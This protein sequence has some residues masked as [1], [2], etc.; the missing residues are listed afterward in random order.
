M[1]PALLSII[2]EPDVGR[3]RWL[4]ATRPSSARPRRLVA[5][6]SRRGVADDN[7]WRAAGNWIGLRPA[8]HSQIDSRRIEVLRYSWSVGIRGPKLT[9]GRAGR[10]PYLPAPF[11]GIGYQTALP[12]GRSGFFFRPRFGGRKARARLHISTQPKA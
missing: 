11:T 9:P 7:Q 3:R 4:V 8:A 12:L 10:R 5:T 6:V 1:R 2:A